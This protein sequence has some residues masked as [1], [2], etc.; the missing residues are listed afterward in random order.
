VYAEVTRRAVEVGAT[1]TE[2]SA[3]FDAMDALSA[4]YG[5]PIGIVEARPCSDGGT[6]WAITAALVA[7]DPNG[8]C[9]V[10]Y[11]ASRE[12]AVAEAQGRA[13]RKGWAA[14]EYILVVIG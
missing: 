12:T 7:N 2:T 11:S 4:E 1:V 3:H 10:G 8:K 14:G 6:G 13:D 9:G 5:K